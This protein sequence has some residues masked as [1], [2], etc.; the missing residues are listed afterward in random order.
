[1]EKTLIGTRTAA[2]EAGR[3]HQFF[4]YRLEEKRRYGV[5]IRKQNGETA[6]LADLTGDRRRIDALLGAL[7]RGTVTPVS[8][9][10]VVEDWLN[11]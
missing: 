6:A 9:R 11:R 8:L 7:L 4:Y 1:M 10:D 2:D 5:C 3:T